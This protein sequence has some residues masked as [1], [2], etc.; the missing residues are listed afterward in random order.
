MC[1]CI[2]KVRCAHVCTHH[3]IRGSIKGLY[4]CH[5]VAIIH[6]I[7]YSRHARHDSGLHICERRQ[8]IMTI[9]KNF[10]CS[11]L[12]YMAALNIKGSLPLHLLILATIYTKI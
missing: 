10:D 7:E 8:S 2:I 5:I 1:L 9:L 12:V 4:I 6:L 11:S 3:Q